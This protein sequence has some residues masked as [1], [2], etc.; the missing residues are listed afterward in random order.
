VSTFATRSKTSPSSDGSSQTQR[1]PFGEYV[2]VCFATDERHTMRSVK[3]TGHVSLCRA[4]QEIQET[5][6]KCYLAR[7]A[8]EVVH[9]ARLV[10]R[11]VRM[12]REEP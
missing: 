9:N 5:W 12:N 3:R 11:D 7:R 6:Q 1:S 8:R 4:V 2:H 10:A